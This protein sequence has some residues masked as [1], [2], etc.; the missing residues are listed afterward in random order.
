[1]TYSIPQ[2]LNVTLP[3]QAEIQH[4][5]IERGTDFF[6]TY[7]YKDSVT[8]LA[9]DLTGYSATLT[10]VDDTQPG[11]SAVISKSTTIQGSGLTIP[12]PTSG[13]IWVVT[14]ASETSSLTQ[15]LLGYD[16]SVTS[17]AGVVTKILKGFITLV[18]TVG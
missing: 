1:M 5:E 6:F 11:N 10:A 16:L 15:N 4:L 13:T 2:S 3:A 18:D 12:S 9:K 17:P 7:V 14:A 8:G